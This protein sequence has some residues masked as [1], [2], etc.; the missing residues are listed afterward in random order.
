[1]SHCKPQDVD[2]AQPPRP[3]RE[4]R[5]IGCGKVFV[6][7]PQQAMPDRC[8]RCDGNTFEAGGLFPD[9]GATI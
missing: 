6:S 3:A 5:C 7:G 2:P 8:R 4:W 1:M 9:K